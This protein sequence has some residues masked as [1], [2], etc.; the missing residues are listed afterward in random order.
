MN[1]DGSDC[2][3]ENTGSDSGIDN[4][5]QQDSS[6]TKISVFICEIC[7]QL[8]FFLNTDGSD[9]T[10]D[11]TDSDWHGYDFQ[12]KPENPFHR[13]G[14]VGALRMLPSMPAENTSS[15]FIASLI[16]GISCPKIDKRKTE[17]THCLL[18]CISA[19]GF[20]AKRG[21]SSRRRCPP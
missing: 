3:D 20:P 7:V 17:K 9:C 16:R 10:D 14:S 4:S 5:P 8:F 12:E 21:F 2:T 1:T 6:S 13:F 15:S 19:W 18:S 11:I